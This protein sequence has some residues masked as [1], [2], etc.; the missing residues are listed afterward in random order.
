[1]TLPSLGIFYNSEIRNNGTARRVTETFYR[2]GYMDA[3][4][5]RY[6]RPPYE[7]EVEKHDFHLY[8]DDGR[9]D[10]EYMPSGPNACWLIDT[11]LGYDQRLAWARQ[12][13]HVFVAQKPAVAKMKA[14]GI[15]NVHWLPLACMPNVDPNPVEAVQYGLVEELPQKEWDVVFVGYL[16]QGSDDGEGNN[17]LEY[18]DYVWE[19]I[20]NNWLAFNKF[21][22][23]TAERGWKSR[24]FFNISIKD[25]L[26]MRFFEVMSYGTCLVTNTDVVGWDEL[27]FEEGKHFVGYVGKEEAAE[28]VQW[29]LDHPIERETIAAAGH[30][31]A[32]AEHTYE[33]RV[34]QMLKTCGV[35]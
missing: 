32:R 21:F 29:A 6:N 1:M 4:T 25:D 12:F 16:N 20:P 23:D 14:D 13:D 11:H 8:I 2:L 31:L 28:R 3:G 7:G 33:H 9:D 34:N 35:L 24:T 17:R 27:G 30:E 10:I 5:K 26:N 18:L 19:K 22:I 15:E